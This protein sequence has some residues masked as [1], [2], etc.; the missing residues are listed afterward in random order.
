MRYTGPIL[1]QLRTIVNKKDLCSQLL[2][3]VLL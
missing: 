3:Q 2:T 1:N